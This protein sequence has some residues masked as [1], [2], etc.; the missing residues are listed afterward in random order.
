VTTSAEVREIWDVEGGV[1]RHRPHGRR[2]YVELVA[3]VVQVLQHG[4]A[5]ED[6][7]AR[8]MVVIL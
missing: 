4:Y 1:H 8:R 5:R 7:G 3:L 2:R 6:V